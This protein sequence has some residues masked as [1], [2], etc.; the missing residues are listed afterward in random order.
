MGILAFLPAAMS[1]LSVVLD[2]LIANP[3]D[4]AKAQLELEKLKQ[5]GEIEKLVKELESDQLEIN[6]TEAASSSF[7]VAGAR[8]FILW[9][10]GT[11]FGF[12]YLIIP[13][14][15]YFGTLFGVD[16][17]YV[18]AF[19]LEAIWPVLGGLLGLSGLRSFDKY[20]GNISGLDKYNGI[21]RGK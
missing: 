17:N 2:K 18:S 12:H 16:L 10:C 21:I 9:L 6:R 8:P 3:M 4:R 11:I 13:A 19:N 14:V 7:F 1:L 20:N 5:S 15:N